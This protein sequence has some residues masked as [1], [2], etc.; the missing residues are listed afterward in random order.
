LAGV[1]I[2]VATKRVSTLT[3]VRP[4]WRLQRKLKQATVEPVANLIGTGREKEGSDA[5]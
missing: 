2:I 4:R 3:P 1:Y 5:G